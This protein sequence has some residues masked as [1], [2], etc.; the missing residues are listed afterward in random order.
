MTIEKFNKLAFKTHKGIYKYHL[1]NLNELK[2]SDKILITCNIHGDFTQIISNHLRGAGCSSCGRIKQGLNKRL[3]KEEF[4]KKSNKVHNNKYNYE[5]VD[6]KYNDDKVKIICPKHGIFEQYV[7][8]HF[9]K[10]KLGCPKCSY[11]KRSED[12]RLTEEE[13]LSKLDDVIIENYSYDLRNYKNMLSKIDITCKIHN[14]SYKQ[15]V[16]SFIKG[17]LGCK[18]CNTTSLGELKIKKF[19]ESNNINFIQQHKFKDCKNKRPLPFDF[20][21]PEYNAVIEFD[22]MQHYRK[23]TRDTK[24]ENLKIRQIRDNIKNKY[25]KN[26]Q[27]P[28]LRI[29]Y[30]ESQNVENILQKFFELE[31]N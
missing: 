10:R 14:I 6:F 27:I 23:S 26:N 30:W 17:N 22:G 7:T 13:F 19:L 25:C 1:N 15:T 31:N 12:R 8:H 5:L 2:W 24:N 21:I 16:Q 29:P 3:T 20:Y 4:I 11:N 9:G 18:K 28:L